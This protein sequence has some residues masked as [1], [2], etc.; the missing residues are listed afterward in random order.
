ML[1]GAG[2]EPLEVVT[3]TLRMR[4]ADASSLLRH[5]FIRLAFLPAWQFVVFPGGITKRCVN[6][7]RAV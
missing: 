6:K 5:Y 2:F 4:F 3:D 1:N 7:E